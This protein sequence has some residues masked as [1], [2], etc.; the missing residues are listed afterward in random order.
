MKLSRPSGNITK[1]GYTAIALTT[2]YT[3][4]ITILG[5]KTM[6]MVKYIYHSNI[7]RNKSNRE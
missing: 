5:L 6:Q 3:I 2:A 1:L 4:I 7:N